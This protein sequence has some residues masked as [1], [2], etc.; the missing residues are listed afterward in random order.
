MVWS[1]ISL[2]GHT[3]L[4]VLHRGTLTAKRY[5]DVI[6]HTHVRLYAGAIGDWFIMMMDGCARPHT[7]YVVQVYLERDY[8]FG[9]ASPIPDLNPLEHV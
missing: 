4:V 9:L 7:A 6:L 3:D 1:G 5:R 8:S 2:D